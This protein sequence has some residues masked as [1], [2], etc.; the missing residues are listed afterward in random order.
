MKKIED[1]NTLVFLCDVRASKPQI[2]D[3]VKKMYNIVAE[4]VNTLVR[5]D[6]QKKA[7]VRLTKDYDALDVASKIGI[8]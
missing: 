5:P 2:R 1:H 4:K 6:G 7:Y 3:A 8:I